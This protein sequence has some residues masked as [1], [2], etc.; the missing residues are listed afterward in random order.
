MK[1][2]AGTSMQPEPVHGKSALLALLASAL[3]G[4]NIVALKYGLDTFPPYWSAWWRFLVGAFVLAIWARSQGTS[5]ELSRREWRPLLIL[6]AMFT[7][8]IL[9]L[10]TGVALTSPAY[11]VV[12]LN[13]HPIFSNLIGH[14][15]A[16]EQRLGPSRSFGLAL[17]FGGICYLALGRPVEALAPNPLLGNPLLI[18]SALLL[19]IRTVY[20][21]RVVQSIPPLRAV[22]WQ[23]FLSLPA[24]LICALTFEPMLLKPVDSPALL[25]ML[26][27]STVIAGFC[28]IIW[29]Q[30]LKKHSAGSLAMYAFAVPIFGVLASAAIFGEPI[31]ARLLFAV[32]LVTAGI[33]IVMRKP[34]NEGR[35]VST[36]RSRTS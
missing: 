29:T 11:A 16:S 4:G 27:Q 25:S 15:V 24:F 26:Y 13:A 30:L 12:I 19:G 22:V 2:P 10:N 3:W 20:T 17:A 5:L 9:L 7:A 6:G 33:A 1:P 36:S 35:G 14:F 23:S 28:F 31:T 8:Q 32:V 21:R 34:K 18:V